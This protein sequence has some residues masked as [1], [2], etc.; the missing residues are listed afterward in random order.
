MKRRLGIAILLTIAATLVAGAA[1]VS[2]T[3]IRRSLVAAPADSMADLPRVILW[4][5]ER[6]ERLSFINPREVGVAFLART[7]YL[8]N[9]DVIVRSRVQPLDVPPDTRLIMVVRIE[10][11]RSAPPALSSGQISRAVSAILEVPLTGAVRALQIDFDARESEREFY[12]GLLSELR[13]QLAPSIRLSITAL[14]SWCVS[15]LWMQGLGVD[16]A[17]PMLFRM[18]V[19]GRSILSHVKAG[20]R[21]GF[22]PCR[23]SVGIST[24]E[25]IKDLPPTMRF[26]VFHPKAWSEESVRKAL[27]EVNQ[28]Q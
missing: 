16:E 14:A 9:D 23:H 11:N 5:W 6:P 21:F 1:L 20:G 15:D 18:G 28:W 17:V 13:R 4:A 12:R 25:P 10:S 26:Y 3:P 27:Q 8:K 22:D 24:D 7:I 2:R 19:D